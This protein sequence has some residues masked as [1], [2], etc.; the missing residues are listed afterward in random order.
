[1]QKRQN[2]QRYNM[3]EDLPEEEWEEIEEEV[4]SKLKGD[5]I[6]VLRIGNN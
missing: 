6:K 3:P 4:E 2:T 5:F 1:M